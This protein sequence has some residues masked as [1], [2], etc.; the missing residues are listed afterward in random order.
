[1]SGLPGVTNPIA[2]AP[3]GQLGYTATAAG[4]LVA[5]SGGPAAQFA[6]A[7]WDASGYAVL[8][9]HQNGN[10]AGNVFVV[11]G[12]NDGGATWNSIAGQFTDAVGLISATTNSG[13]GGS[14]LMQFP[15]VTELIRVRCSTYVSG[16]LSVVPV[17]RTAPWVPANPAISPLP[18]ASPGST[19]SRVKAANTTNATSLKASAGAV[20]SLLLCNTTAAA[21]FFKFYDKAS[22]PTVGTDTPK[23]T[24]PLAANQAI[25]YDVA[26]GMRFTVGI[27]YAITNLVADS[28]TTV[29]A[30]DS[31]HGEVTWI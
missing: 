1:M 4:V 6:P 29:V 2:W 10:S 22:A 7:Q 28:D 25:P 9:L 5:P 30:A 15:C 16:T 12:S 13:V 8:D 20:L 31:V 19:T 11:E 3:N 18:N 17:F 26:Y 21:V 23:F 14:R 24:M 27:A